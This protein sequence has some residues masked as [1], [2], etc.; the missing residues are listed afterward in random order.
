ME[1]DRS[2]TTSAHMS[3]KTQSAALDSFGILAAFVAPGLLA[4]WAVADEF[5]Q[6]GDL[7]RTAATG[8]QDLGG[9]LLVIIAAIAAGLVISAV[10]WLTI[11][12]LHQKLFLV[13]QPKFE[14]KNLSDRLD[15]FTQVVENHYRFY[16]FYANTLV[17]G[18]FA[19]VSG[20]IHHRLPMTPTF[21]IL[22][23]VCALALLWGSRDA[24]EK[25][26]VR[27]TAILKDKE[28]K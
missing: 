27:G 8:K 22:V 15:A 14:F 13:A 9:F 11:D 4:L 23:T 1:V 10:R 12:K 21:W 5:P 19:V 26:H 28:P 17:A 18:V 6:L 25:Y 3:E 7:V 16:Q 20:C 24:L 2:R